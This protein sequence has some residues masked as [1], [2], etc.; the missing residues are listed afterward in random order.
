[1]VFEWRTPGPAVL[2]LA[3]LGGAG[4]GWD[5]VDTICGGA[6]RIWVKPQ[7]TIQQCVTGDQ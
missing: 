4:F 7:P 6:A 3:G 1:M 2:A 5:R